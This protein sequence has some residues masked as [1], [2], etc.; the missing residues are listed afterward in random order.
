MTAE[1]RAGRIRL[2]HPAQEPRVIGTPYFCQKTPVPATDT[3]DWGDRGSIALDVF[4]MSIKRADTLVTHLYSTGYDSSLVASRLKALRSLRGDL[5]FAIEGHHGD[6]LERL[7]P[8]L[9]TTFGDL[10]RAVSSLKEVSDH[11]RAGRCRNAIHHAVM[12]RQHA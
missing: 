6:L 1:P 12:K 9:E 4:D 2:E 7:Q 5:A 8:D 11:T 3:P 10:C